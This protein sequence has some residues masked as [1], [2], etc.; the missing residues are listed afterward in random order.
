[1]KRTVS[2][3][4]LFRDIILVRLDFRSN[5]NLMFIL[6]QNGDMVHTLIQLM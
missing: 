6:D 5:S 1:M 4:N 2:S 3:T